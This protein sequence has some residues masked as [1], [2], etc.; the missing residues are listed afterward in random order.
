M[1]SRGRHAKWPGIVKKYVPPFLA[2]FAKLEMGPP[3]FR[4]MFY[5]LFS[6]GIIENTR[7]SA[8]SLNS[9]ITVARECGYLPINCLADDTRNVVGNFYDDSNYKSPQDE[10]DGMDL[11]FF[12]APAI[13]ELLH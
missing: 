9:R 7:S 13:L 11:F 6:R 10:L 2:E 1:V 12:L 8:N 4:R 3:T 5:N